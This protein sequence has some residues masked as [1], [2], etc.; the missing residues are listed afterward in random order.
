MCTLCSDTARRLP[1][2]AAS[3]PILSMEIAVSG[4]SSLPFRRPLK[5]P[6]PGRRKV[7]PAFLSPPLLT[8]T[9]VERG[10]GQMRKISERIYP[11]SKRMCNG[12]ADVREAIASEARRMVMT[13]AAPIPPGS[14]IS[15]QI[16][17]AAE[18]LGYT[19]R[20]LW[21]VKAAWQLKAGGWSADA[22]ETLKA[23][24]E[25]WDERQ[26]RLADA[27]AKILALRL[28]TIA[29]GVEHTDE[30]LTSSSLHRS[31]ELAR[32]LRDPTK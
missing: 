4:A 8:E 22:W 31:R 19:D 26:K 29:D 20:E 32:R 23:R 30:E 25:A 10:N 13:A 15:M 1:P 27:S 24:Y 18:S 11:N 21:R 17:R 12:S 7:L 14:N 5:L 16:R 3:R 2:P 9:N 6:G 28:A